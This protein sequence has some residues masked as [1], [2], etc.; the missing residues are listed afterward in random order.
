[1]RKLSIEIREMD[2]A[3]EGHTTGL[4]RVLD[5]YASEDMGG[6]VPL[7]AEVRLRLVPALREQANA[8][9]LLA[10][11]EGVVTGIATCF[12]GFST[13]SA[14]PLLNVHDLAV[15]PASRGRGIGR[16]LLVA[17][18]QRARDRGCAKLTLEVREDNARARGLYQERGF[19]DFE[20]AGV[21]YRTFFLAKPLSATP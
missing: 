7:A 5:S 4:L 11:E 14:R 21:S 9:V 13:F 3:N 18:E 17:A 1:M 20:L 19:R 15:L 6:G 16:A 8:L 10:F 2:F 12:F